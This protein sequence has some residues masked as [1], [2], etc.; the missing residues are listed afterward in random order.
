M[1]I[2]PSTRSCIPI[3]QPRFLICSHHADSHPFL[4]RFR[5]LGCVAR[6]SRKYSPQPPNHR[7]LSR[8]RPHHWHRPICLC[9]LRRILPFQLIP[10][11]LLL[12]CRC[13]RAYSLPPYAALSPLRQEREVA[14][15]L[16]A[17]R[18]RRLALLQCHFTYGCAQLSGLAH[19]FNLPFNTDAHKIPL[20]GIVAIILAI[21]PALGLLCST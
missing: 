15:S 19:F 8:L 7:C 3:A 16:S 1:R 18:H 2:I 14:K 4:F 11:R 5:T 13:L 9:I 17:T 21:E 10:S 6:V 20:S 12:L